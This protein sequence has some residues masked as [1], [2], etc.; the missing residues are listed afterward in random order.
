MHVLAWGAVNAIASDGARK[1]EEF[2]LDYTGGWGKYYLARSGTSGCSS[3]STARSGSR[4]A[5]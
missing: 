5:T 1:Q 3:P 2:Q 4:R